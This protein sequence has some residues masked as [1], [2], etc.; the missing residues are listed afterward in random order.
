MAMVRSAPAI[1]A[2]AAI[3]VFSLVLSG[4]GKGARPGS[5]PAAAHPD[6][7]HDECREEGY[8]GGMNF[9]KFCDHRDPVEQEMVSGLYL[10]RQWQKMNGTGTMKVRMHF[11]IG[12][13]LWTSTSYGVIDDKWGEVHLE[14]PSGKARCLLMSVPTEEYFT[15]IRSPNG[16]DCPRSC[17]NHPV[18][19]L[20]AWTGFVGEF[21]YY[22]GQCNDESSVGRGVKVSL[23]SQHVIPF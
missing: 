10:H 16:A 15:V 7:L 18:G 13:S 3:G 6:L 14:S 17:K 12:E 19:T 21:N 23:H 2:A 22:S 4:C 11:N 5:S 1:V 9:T 8:E 20:E